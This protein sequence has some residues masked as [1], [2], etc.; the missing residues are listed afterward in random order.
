[1][2]P[3]IIEILVLAGIA[4]FLVLR[5]KNVLG[6]REGFEKPPLQESSPSKNTRDFRVID[7]GEDTDITDNID[8][9]SPSA[10][11][12]AR[13]KKVD[14]GFLVNEFLSGARSAYEMIL[15]AFENGD[16]KEVEVFLDADVQDAFQQ[17]INTRAEKKLKVVAE[18]YGIRELSLKSADFDEKTKIA[19]LSVAFTGELSSVVKNEEGEIIEGDAK[20]VKRQ[21]DTWTFSRDLSSTDPNWLLVAT[22]S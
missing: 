6:T 22:S 21:K 12:L 8:K 16:L 7:G 18:F 15:M 4:I 10:D 20:Q 3:A 11:A 14:S 5:L 17:V 19:E 13:M 1:M 9:K 2:S